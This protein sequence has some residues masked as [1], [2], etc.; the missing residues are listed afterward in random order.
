MISAEIGGVDLGIVG[1]VVQKIGH[2][3]RIH[4]VLASVSDSIAVCVFL[5]GIVN[6]RT[7]VLFVANAVVIGIRIAVVAQTVRVGIA[8]VA[9]RYGRTVVQRILDTVP[10]VCIVKKKNNNRRKLST[11]GAGVHV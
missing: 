11:A 7:V 9:V 6:N 3:V 8:L 5:I 10:I 4:I 2:I 1:T